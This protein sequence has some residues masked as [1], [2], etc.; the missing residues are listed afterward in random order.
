MDLNRYLPH[1]LKNAWASYNSLNL[2]EYMI[3]WASVGNIFGSTVGYIALKERERNKTSDHMD[4]TMYKVPHQQIKPF[5]SAWNDQSRVTQ[6]QPGY[7][8]TK[9]FK[10]IAWDHSPYQYV[11]VRMWSE[12]SYLDQWLT[13]DDAVFSREKIQKD[14][15]DS[16]LRS[17]GEKF[18][19]V[20]DDSVVRL[21]H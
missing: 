3:L 21:I 4:V 2:T 12:K 6:M 8:W 13:S 17:K 9:M 14:S 15:G 5:E 16:G 7:E 19:T 10:A 18:V 1:F 11:L 20:V